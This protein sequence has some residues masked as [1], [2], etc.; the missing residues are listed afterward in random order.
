MPGLVP[1]PE[2]HANE[3]NYRFI[4]ADIC[5]SAAVEEIFAR[6]KPVKVIHLAAE[7]MWTAALLT[8]SYLFVL[9]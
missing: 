4:K 5:D 3:N 2:N 8:H 9:M 6:Y 1:Y 7:S